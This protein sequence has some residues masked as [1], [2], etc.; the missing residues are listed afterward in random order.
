MAKKIAVIEDEPSISQLYKLKLTR[1][2]YEV[3][4][5]GNGRDGLVLIAK[6]LPDLILLDLLMPEMSGEEMLQALRKTEHGKNIKVIILTNVSR[7]EAPD[8][9]A[10]LNISRY[11]VK[12][13][14]TPEQVAATVKSAL[15]D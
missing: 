13:E 6:E 3:V 14:Y 2:G 5:A 4:T 7:Q 8:S 12:A 11:I 15:A 9:L 1:E 10:N